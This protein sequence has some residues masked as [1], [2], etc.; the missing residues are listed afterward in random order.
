MAPGARRQL[1][2]YCWYVP[3][4]AA[5]P[6]VGP[7]SSTCPAQQIEVCVNE[8]S[9]NVLK[10]ARDI[11]IVQSCN[12]G[13]PPPATDPAGPA[14]TVSPAMIDSSDPTSNPPPMD[15]IPAVTANPPP[16]DPATNKQAVVVVTV[17]SCYHMLL[18][19]LRVV[20]RVH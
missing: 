1:K 2:D 16:P 13:G 19:E 17:T 20:G 6:G 11:K 3:C 8:A 12:F 15:D 10:A 9:Q 5:E 7:P 14:P 4:Q 18:Q